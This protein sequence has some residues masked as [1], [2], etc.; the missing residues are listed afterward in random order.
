VPLMQ[1]VG[2]APYVAILSNADYE[3]E[4]TENGFEIVES[5]KHG[6]TKQD[7]RTFFVARKKVTSGRASSR[8]A[9]V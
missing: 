3:R 7:V 9:S 1:A 6:S 2:Q 8:C 5:A 4:I